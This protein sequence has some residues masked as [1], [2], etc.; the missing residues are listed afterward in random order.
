[1]SITDRGKPGINTAD[2]TQTRW[3]LKGGND[4][5]VLMAGWTAHTT[6]WDRFFSRWFHIPLEE[7]TVAIFTDH[8]EARAYMEW[9]ESTGPR[10]AGHRFRTD[11]LLAGYNRAWLDWFWTE[12]PV[13]PPRPRHHLRALRSTQVAKGRNT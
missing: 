12:H 6:W 1:M 11:S 7:H 13:N 3:R 4:L 8:H 2:L 9:A 10:P 5:T